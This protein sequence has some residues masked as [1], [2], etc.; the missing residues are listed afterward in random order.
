MKL[1]DHIFLID[2]LNCHIRNKAYNSVRWACL[3]SLAPKREVPISRAIGNGEIM[4][5]CFPKHSRMGTARMKED[6]E[7]DEDG[8]KR[9]VS[10]EK[11]KRARKKEVPTAYHYLTKI[12]Y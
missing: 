11:V 9:D 10:I 8:Q 7:T 6:N 2:G 12:H 5:E 3:V 1:E 4:Q